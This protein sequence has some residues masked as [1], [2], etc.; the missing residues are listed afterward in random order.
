MILYFIALPL[1]ISIAASVCGDISGEG[2]VTAYDAALAARIAVEIDSEAGKKE[3][4]DVSGDG[5]ITSYDA[6]LIAQK[7]VGLVASLNCN[8]ACSKIL[9]NDYPV[10]SETYTDFTNWQT[11]NGL[12]EGVDASSR[13]FL[14]SPVI[15][16]GINNEQIHHDIKVDYISTNGNKVRVI[17]GHSPSNNINDVMKTYY[18]TNGEMWVNSGQNVK[19]ASQ[20]RSERYSWIILEIPS[21][22]T[23][24]EVEHTYWIGYNTE[25]GH[26]G[27]SMVSSQGEDIYYRLLLPK[28]YD[29]SDDRYYPLIISCPGSNGLG[30]GNEVQMTMTIYGRYAFEK[31]YDTSE[32]EV[33]SL[34]PAV[35]LNTKTGYYADVKEII[36]SL[37]ADCSVKIDTNKIYFTGNSYGGI[38]SYEILNLYPQLWAAVWPLESP[39]VGVSTY[40]VP[41]ISGSGELDHYS[42]DGEKYC[43]SILKAGGVCKHYVYPGVNHGGA[44]GSSFTNINQLRWLLSQKI[45][46]TCVDKDSDGYGECPN[47]AKING[48]LYEEG[49]CDDNDPTSWESEAVVSDADADG[50]GLKGTFIKVCKNKLPMQGFS[51]VSGDCDDSDA[52]KYILQP[53]MYDNDGDGWGDANQSW[54]KLCTASTLP[55][56]YLAASDASS[57]YRNVSLTKWKDCDDSNPSVHPGAV[58]LC[59]GIDDNCNSLIDEGCNV[60]P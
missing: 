45:D 43:Q 14:I 41:V 2:Y 48:C 28:N 56:G 18:R 8:C 60:A 59:N 22:V 42:E 26:T 44:A 36:D 5:E 6:A 11:Y 16:V 35:A 12:Y 27:Y 15:D 57:N 25:Y 32:F 47:C 53:V 9:K 39:F 30:S 54:F 20:Y 4:A 37:I 52:N 21:G 24:T 50:F 58:E 38:A 10:T 40:S 49:D 3:V 7:A 34:V 23:L 51:L 13:T 55:S 33:I 19:I 46:R 31:Y 29:S 17:L 1:Q